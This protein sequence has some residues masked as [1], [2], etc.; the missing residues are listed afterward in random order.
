MRSCFVLT[1]ED[2]SDFSAALNCGADMVLLRHASPLVGGGRR[3]ARDR[4]RAVIA[5]A[6]EMSGAPQ[7][8][9]EVASSE[10][11]VVEADLDSLV[12]VAPD[13]VFLRACAGR[14]NLRQLAV[15]LAVREAK[16]G[17]PD[18][19]TKIAAFVGGDPSAVLA[20][21][22]CAGATPRLAALAFDEAGLRAAMGLDEA[23]AA[24]IATA[25]ALVVL[26]ASAAGVP[27]LA[28]PVARGDEGAYAVARRD[29]FSGAIT[30]EA[31]QIER[32]H[33]AFT[34]ARID[35]RPSSAA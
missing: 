17:L 29:G 25:R 31:A 30:L 32:V 21:A 4:A 10:G 34:A 23:G 2:D 16:A 7:I 3:R 12:S 11:D 35:K 28:P 8:F 1:I 33:A 14:A 9:V 26:A 19:V 15:K 6:R 24:P 27:A 20:L 22:T 13:G 5:A 18:G